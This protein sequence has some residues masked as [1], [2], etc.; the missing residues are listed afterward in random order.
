[1]QIKDR[2]LK[3]KAAQAF[4]DLVEEQFLNPDAPAEDLENKIGYEAAQIYRSIV[5]QQ[6]LALANPSLFVSVSK[7]GVF[8]VS[9]NDMELIDLNVYVIDETRSDPDGNDVT[10]IADD[11]SPYLARVKKLPVTATHFE[12]EAVVEAAAQPSRT[13]GAR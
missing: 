13:L 11:E 3:D 10:L 7:N 6:D 1:M 9:S 12:T 2:M 5:G 4:R 8:D